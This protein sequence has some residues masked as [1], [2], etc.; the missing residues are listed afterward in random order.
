MFRENLINYTIKELN[1]TKDVLVLVQ[2]TEDPKS[3]FDTKNETKYL[4][5]SEAKSEVKNSILATRVRKY[6]ERE[7]RLVS[8]MNKNYGII[9]GQ[10]TSVL[11]SILKG[12][13]DFSSKS[14]N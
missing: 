4:N 7:V 9:W 13:E 10:C 5:E 12:N 11:N 14:K 2:D 3:S 1:K 6:I 8:N